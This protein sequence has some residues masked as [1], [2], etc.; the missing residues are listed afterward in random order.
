MSAAVK[1]SRNRLV[2]SKGASVL[3]EGARRLVSYAGSS[4]NEGFHLPSLPRPENFLHSRSNFGKNVENF[5]KDSVFFMLW[6]G[7]YEGPR[8]ETNL[9]TN[10]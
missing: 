7:D 9:W 1:G 8:R 10:Q 5:L 2:L 3:S 6:T 4:L